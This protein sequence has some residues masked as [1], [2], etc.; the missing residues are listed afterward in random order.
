MCADVTCSFRGSQLVKTKLSNKSRRIG[1]K[2]TRV[3][4]CTC[5]ADRAEA[6]AE[7]VR[8]IVLRDGT[9][10]TE[11]NVTPVTRT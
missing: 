11:A 7:S 10:A 4:E 9:E 1:E 3:D 5:R 8:I 2:G 6:C